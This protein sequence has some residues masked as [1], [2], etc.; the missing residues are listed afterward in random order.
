[1]VTFKLRITQPAGKSV[2]SVYLLQCLYKLRTE[3]Q[4]HLFYGF[5]F[6]KSLWFLKYKVK[7]REDGNNFLFP[8]IYKQ[9]GVMFLYLL[10][11]CGEL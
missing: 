5:V 2:F 11:E 4:R 6:L 8:F 7:Q 10:L 3:T 9:V 1:M